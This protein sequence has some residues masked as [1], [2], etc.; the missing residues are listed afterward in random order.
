MEIEIT[1]G[2]RKKKN[3]PIDKVDGG[4]EEKG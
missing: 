1:N 2:S 3:K 4:I